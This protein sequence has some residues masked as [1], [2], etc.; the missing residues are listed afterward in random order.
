MCN[1][2]NNNNNNDGKVYNVA[3]NRMLC[4]DVAEGLDDI[5]KRDPHENGSNFDPVP[6]FQK[7][8]VPV[9]EC[10][11]TADTCICLL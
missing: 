2:N 1:N 8:K 6:T 5:A 3:V 7:A 4:N 10:L 11:Y 9:S